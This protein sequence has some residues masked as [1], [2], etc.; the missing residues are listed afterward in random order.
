MLVIGVD[1]GGTFTDFVF[2]DGDRWGVYKCLSSPDNPARA[3]LEGLRRIAGKR[4]KRVVHGSTV[5]TNAIL[6]R[7]GART[8][9]VTNAGFE[10]LIEIGRQNRERLY[11]LAYRR[12]PHV[13][14]AGL[15]FGVGGRIL[16]TGEILEPL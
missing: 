9:L 4:Q 10:D 14:P 5:A 12:E 13:V 3:V 7:K 8:A 15:R 16:H 2:R 6:E 1:T 11:D